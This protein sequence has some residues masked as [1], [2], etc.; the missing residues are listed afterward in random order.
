M[1]ILEKQSLR[2]KK[3]ILYL[4]NNHEYSVGYALLKVEE[5]YDSGKLVEEDYEELAEYLEDLLEEEEKVVE[6]TAENTTEN[7]ENTAE[8]EETTPMEEGGEQWN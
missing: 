6:N 7:V 4:V 8:V 3:S 2:K 1:T 5:L